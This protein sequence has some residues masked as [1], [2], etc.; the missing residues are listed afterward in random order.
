MICAV[1]WA[2]FVLG[3]VFMFVFELGFWLDF[4]LSFG[5]SFRLLG[6]LGFGLDF[7]VSF[8]LALGWVWIRPCAGLRAFDIVYC[9]KYLQFN[10]KLLKY[11]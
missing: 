10:E 1:L 11:C 6:F 9:T 8:G 4:E 7:L 2:D 5:L 3:F